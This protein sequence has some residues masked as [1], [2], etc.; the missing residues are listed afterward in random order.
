MH[1]FFVNA[2]RVRGPE[3]NPL[4]ISSWTDPTHF[5]SEQATAP[6]PHGLR[7][8]AFEPS[9]AIKTDT[10]Q[11]DTPTGLEVELTFPPDAG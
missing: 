1:P 9:V 3:A 6:A 10:A 8:D 4:S 7:P 11:P 5:E 2:T